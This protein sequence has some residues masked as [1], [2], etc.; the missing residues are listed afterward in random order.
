[1]IGAGALVLGVIVVVVAVVLISSS[2]DD[3]MAAIGMAPPSDG[4]C[5]NALSGD[6]AQETVLVS[7]GVNCETAVRVINGLE[8]APADN[9]KLIGGGKT[10]TVDG[11]GWSCGPP[12]PSTEC[13]SDE[14]TVTNQIN[15]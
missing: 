9:P 8:N 4:N 13:K 10:V 14:G 5:G 1:M 15:P 12:T 6:R 11:T 7:G 2:G 3:D